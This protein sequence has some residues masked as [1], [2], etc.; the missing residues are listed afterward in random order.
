MITVTEKNYLLKHWEEQSR[1]FLENLAAI[2]IKPG[3]RNIHDLRVA[4][5]KLK[6]ALRLAVH[7]ADE[8][9]KVD[10]ETIR[11]LFRL[12]GKYRDVEISIFLLRKIA[13]DETLELPSL[14]RNLRAMLAVTRNTAKREALKDQE[15]E[16]AFI[17]NWISGQLSPVSN[18][19]LEKK[20][21]EQV[22]IITCGLKKLLDKFNQHAHEIRIQLKQLYYWL[23]LSEVNPFFD[24][25]QMKI[26]DKALLALGNWHD[27]FVLHEKIRRFRKEY[28]VKNSPEYIH[29]RKAE[30]IIKLLQEQWLTDARLRLEK[31]EIL[32]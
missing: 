14:S 18:E 29:T 6:S 15:T 28:L 5:K 23:K 12:T 8:E 27:Y 21:E 17:H 30:E 31:L 7:F 1:V 2:R 24:K 11:L 9:E 26:L 16:L 3:K 19:M 13:R 22:A 32:G 4:I 25:R 20:I 10:F